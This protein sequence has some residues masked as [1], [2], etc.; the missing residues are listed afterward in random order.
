MGWNSLFWYWRYA[1]S[2]KTLDEVLEEELPNNKIGVLS[3]PS[4]AEEVSRN[5]PTLVVAASYDKEAA[6]VVQQ[7]FSNQY[8]SSL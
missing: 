6:Q 7:T 8:F 1:I 4:H 5:V 3:G 2:N